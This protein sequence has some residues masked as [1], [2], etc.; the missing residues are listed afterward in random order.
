MIRLPAFPALAIA[1]WALGACSHAVQSR[2]EPIIRTVE[3]KVPVVQPCP[4]LEALGPSPAYPDSDAALAAAPNLYERVKL[5]LA[6]RV[7]RITREGNVAAI[8]QACR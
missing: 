2:P 4:A 1:V 6:G 8:V 7:L 3:V 5:L